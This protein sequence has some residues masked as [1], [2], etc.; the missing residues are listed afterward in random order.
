M[1]EWRDETASVDEQ[2]D[3][4][5]TLIREPVAEDKLAGVLYLQEYLTDRVPWRTALPRYAEL[6]DSG[7]AAW[8]KAENLWRA[9]ASAVAFV[10]L[11][12]DARFHDL[13]ERSCTTLIR[14]DERFAKTAVGWVLREL[15]RHDP[16]RVERFVREYQPHFSR[17]YLRRT[18]DAG[19]VATRVP[20]PPSRGRGLG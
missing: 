11:T 2:F 6:F 8:H 10:Y 13:I 14:R 19:T 18:G 16:A 17:E 20:S 12:A 15:S 5:L 9:R 4:A 3:V 1:A 7:V